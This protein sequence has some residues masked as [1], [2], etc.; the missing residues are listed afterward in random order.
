MDRT[1]RFDENNYEF[2]TASKKGVYLIHGF[3][4]TTYETK[5]LAEYLSTKGYYTV[6]N[7][8]PGHGTSIKECNRIKYTDWITAVEQDVATLASKCDTIHV[9]GGSMG[10]VL[11]LHLSTIFP[12]NSLIFTN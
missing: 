5:K 4:N 10:G 1:P 6:A 8:L 7:N 12:I 11:A 3:T 2:N 9:I